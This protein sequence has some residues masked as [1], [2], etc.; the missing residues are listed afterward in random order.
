LRGKIATISDGMG[1]KQVFGPTIK[2]VLDW[3]ADIRRRV[4]GGGYAIE[5]DEPRQPKVLPPEIA[6]QR[7]HARVIKVAP[8]NPE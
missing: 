6:L 2:N 1:E 8:A 3:E 7:L 4:D 5:V